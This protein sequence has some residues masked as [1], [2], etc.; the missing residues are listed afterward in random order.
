MYKLSQV[1]EHV[2]HNVR[3]EMTISHNLASLPSPKDAHTV[4]CQVCWLD[5][6]LYSS[7]NL[8]GHRSGQSSCA[9]AWFTCINNNNI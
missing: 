8:T 3:H 7:I 4:H 6:Q 5:R 1:S 2:F 9:K